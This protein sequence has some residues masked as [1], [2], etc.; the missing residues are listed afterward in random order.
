MTKATAVRVCPNCQA[1]VTGHGSQVYCSEACHRVHRNL[2]R[3]VNVSL[4]SCRAGRCNRLPDESGFCHVHSREDE[5]AWT[6]ADRISDF[7]WVDGGWLTAEGLALEF[8]CHPDSARRS[9]SQLLREG[10]VRRRLVGL[11]ASR[12]GRHT[13]HESREEWSAA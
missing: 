10:R 3:R 11:A 8:A 13:L 7:L 1:E 9:L 4:R 12:N 2:R 6:L 5:P